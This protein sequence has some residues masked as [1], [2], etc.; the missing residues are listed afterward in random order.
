QPN[1]KKGYSKEWPFL[2]LLKKSFRNND[3]SLCSE[4]LGIFRGTDLRL[5]LSRR[6]DVCNPGT[7]LA[8]T[9]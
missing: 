6:Q 3:L 4:P 1:I 5:C 9:R 8:D 7:A 2:Y